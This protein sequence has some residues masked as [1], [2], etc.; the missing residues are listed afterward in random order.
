VYTQFFGLR[1]EPF[2]I[3]PDPRYLYM[4]ERHR[5]ALAHLLY[6]VSGGGGF[7]LLTGEIGA[8]KTT[9]C[10]CFLEQVP[11]RTNVAYVFNPALSVIELLQT[12]CDEF[13]IPVPPHGGTGTPTVKD[14]V[15]ALNRF[16]L[17][18]HSVGQNS[19]LIIDEAQSLSP[20]VIEQLRLLTN[21]ETTERKLLQIIL[22]GQPEL[23]TMLARPELEQVAQRVIARYHLDALSEDETRRYIRHRLTVAGA[24]GANPFNREAMQRLHALARG[25]P[26][27]INL[28][29]DRALLGAYAGGRA[30]VD[31]E[32]VE[33]AAAEVF[34]APAVAAAPS[35]RRT[36]L[37]TALGA[38]GGAILLAAVF[39]AWE[40]GRRSTVVAPVATA[41]S[42]A[43]VSATPASAAAPAASSAAAV[44]IADPAQVIAALPQ[45]ERAAWAEI[46]PAWKISAEGEDPCAAA[47]REQVH[48]FRGNASAALLRQL[49]RPVIL[50]LR[51]DAGRTAFAP[52]VGLAGDAASVRIGGA[53]QQLPWAALERIWRGEFATFWRA[54]PGYEPPIVASRA[55]EAGRWLVE[56]LAR[57]PGASRR[58][59]LR[60][61]VIAFQSSQGLPV[62]GLAGPM[63]LM[64]LNR[65]AGI[66]EPRLAP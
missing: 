48:C 30:A 14:H 50:S 15:D 24:R 25:I 38:A 58:D 4:S 23:R 65:V 59:P 62:D 60:A 46:A 56:Q 51:D 12:V 40:A 17:D 43:A 3:A 42:A 45:N 35:R 41:A 44:A 57:L 22:I 52:L 66:D 13:H 47:L 37:A 9:V 8:G 39:W 49:A 63:T 26:R 34:D 18:T 36:V 1:Q 27:R 55:G 5:E 7:V 31:T 33:R 2:S 29:A 6:G 11:S 21:L 19:V 53:V 61:Q 16:L 32:M 10:R 64:Q 28:L 20:E 54:P